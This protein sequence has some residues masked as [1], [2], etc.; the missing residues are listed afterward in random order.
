MKSL[1]IRHRADWNKKEFYRYTAGRW[2]FDEEHQMSSRYVEFN[3]N[4]LVRIA[5]ECIGSP[6]CAE[7]IKLPEGNFN[8]AFLLT[9]TDGNQM[10]VKVPNPNAGRAHYTT[11]S[12]VA[13]MDFVG[14]LN[15]NFYHTAKLWIPP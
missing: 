11:A 13:T 15:I 14:L 1:L 10:V 8:K 4:E 2:L 12:E 3:M 7:V 9:M 6:A 5:A